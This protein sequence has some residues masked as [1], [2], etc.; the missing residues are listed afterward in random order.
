MKLLHSKIKKK[1]KKKKNT[2]VKKLLYSNS[3]RNANIGNSLNNSNI[4]FKLFNPL[5]QIL[6]VTLN[7]QKNEKKLPQK[8]IIIVIIQKKKK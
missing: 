6:K 7:E 4:E 3:K 2:L 5:T 1:R 8:I